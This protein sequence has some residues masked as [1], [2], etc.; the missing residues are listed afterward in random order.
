MLVIKIG[1]ILMTA[2]L[3]IFSILN[4]AQTKEK[5][6]VIAIIVIMIYLVYI[7]IK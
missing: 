7:L 4:F 6:D 1:L 3:L 5:E 2:L